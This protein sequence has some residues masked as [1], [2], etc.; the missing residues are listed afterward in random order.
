MVAQ[1]FERGE[2]VC[3]QF[4]AVKCPLHLAAL[5]VGAGIAAER[6]QSVGTKGKVACLGGTAH[7]VFDV[8]IEAAV[9]VDDED[10]GKRACC[11]CGLGHKAFDF[12]VAIGAVIGDFHR[13]D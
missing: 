7:D 13:F 9:F 2:E 11:P 10:C 5:F 6:G 8:R 4:A 1:E 12:T 3:H